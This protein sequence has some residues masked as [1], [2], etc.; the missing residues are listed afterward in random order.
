M[1]FGEMYAWTNRLNNI[2]EVAGPLKQ[3][4]LES[5]KIDLELATNIDNCLFARRFHLRVIE[6]LKVYGNWE[7]NRQKNS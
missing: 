1:T 4:R 3:K 7:V 6:E 5:L 2:L